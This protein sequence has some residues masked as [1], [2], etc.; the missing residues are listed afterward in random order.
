MKLIVCGLLLLALWAR[1]AAIE[2][3]IQFT[4]ADA[5]RRSSVFQ[6]EFGEMV[7]ATCVWRVAKVNGRDIVFAEIRVTNTDSKPLWFH[8]SVAFFDKDKKLLGA[9][10]RTLFDEEGLQPGKKPVSQMCGVYLPKDKYKD[11]ASY[12]AVIYDLDA[13]PSTV[14]KKKAMVLEDP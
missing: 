7:K 2:G 3:D 6:K 5:T 10:G 4:Y 13:P 12:Q 14:V 9:A 1:A 11:I 8:Y